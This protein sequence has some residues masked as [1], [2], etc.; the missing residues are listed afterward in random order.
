MTCLPSYDLQTLPIFTFATKD[1]L[2]TF[3]LGQKKLYLRYI[4]LAIF[5]YATITPFHKNP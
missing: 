2:V 5:T 3:Q 1:T 4:S